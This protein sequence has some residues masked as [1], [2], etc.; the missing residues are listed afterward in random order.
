M[1][2]A[3]NGA[4]SLYLSMGLLRWY[5]T[6]RSERPRYAPLVLLPAELVRKAANKGYGLRLRDEE[7]VMNVTLLEMLKQNFGIVV[8]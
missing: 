6:E 1:S 2:I 5:E 7:P 3:E 8:D 4:N